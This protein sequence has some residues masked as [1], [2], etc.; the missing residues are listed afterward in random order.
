MLQGLGNRQAGTREGFVYVMTNPAWPGYV[1]VGRALDPF[2]RLASYQ[3]SDPNRAYE[4]Q[5]YRYFE[6]RYDAERMIQRL[7]TPWWASGEWYRVPVAD[8]LSLLEG[9]HP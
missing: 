8:A 4:I 2:D 5:A 9:I 7:L 6:D 3:T 1:K